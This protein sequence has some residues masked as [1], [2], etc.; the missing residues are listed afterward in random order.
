MAILVGVDAGASR[1]TAFAADGT[2]NV[3]ARASGAPGAVRPGAVRESAEAILGTVR[4]VLGEAGAERA[5]A[6]V[7]GAAGAGREPERSDLERALD[8]AAV[9]GAVRVTTDI[10]I[11]LV[12]AL[13]DEPGILLLAGTG[14]GACAR[15]PSAEIKRTGGHGWQFGDEGSGYA[16]A[17]AALSAVARA[18]DGRGS[19][20]R[21]TE[22]L[23]QAASVRTA[24]ELL[25][26]ARAAPRQ[27]I[28]DLAAKVQDTAHQEDSVAQ[29]LVAQAARDLMGHVPPLRS[30]F[31]A[32]GGVPL[33]LAGGLVRTRTPMRQAVT[34]IVEAEMP[35]LRLLDAVVEPAQGALRLAQ[36]LSPR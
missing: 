26:W 30:Q 20:T 17:R 2:L 15:L 34:R 32:A 18:S 10:E 8:A 13:G 11:A 31:P 33:A 1:S 35:G 5:A 27:A 24:D 22:V 9:A 28:A 4:R 23:T 3:L 14:S 36:R 12:A 21:L 29:R 19:A 16:L 6:L 25:Q 7:V